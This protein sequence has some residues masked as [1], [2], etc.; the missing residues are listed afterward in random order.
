MIIRLICLIL[1]MSGNALAGQVAPSNDLV[2]TIRLPEVKIDLKAGP[3][4]EKTAGY[5]SVC[6]SLDYITTQP[7]FAKEKWGEIVAKM[8]KVFGA[9][10]P[11]DVAEEISSYLGSAYGKNQGGMR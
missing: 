4:R 10:I 2:H 5:C 8:V 6:H 3:G 11:Q 1:I 9:P 7:G